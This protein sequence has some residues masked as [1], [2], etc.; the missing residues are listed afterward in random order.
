MSEPPGAS[1]EAPATVPAS[2]GDSAA[3][4]LVTF[5]VDSGNG[6]R[7]APPI[8]FRQP[9][10]AGDGPEPDAA[11]PGSGGSSPEKVVP[12]PGAGE[13]IR[14]LDRF[15]ILEFVGQGSYGTVSRAWDP[16]LQ[17]F[18]ALKELHPDAAGASSHAER[19]RREARAAV[20]LSHPGIV[21]L[22]EVLIFNNRPVLVYDF[23][24]GVTLEALLEARRLNFAEAARLV[25]ELADALAYAHSMK[26]VHRDVKPGNIL[27]ACP[28]T[29]GTPLPDP[30]TMPVDRPV[31]V[32]F[33]LARREEAEAPL[34]VEGQLL[35]TFAYMSPEQAAGQGHQA[36][37]RSD[38]YSLGVVLYKA[39][40]GELPFRGSKVTLLHSI[41]REE[42]RR[43]RSLNREIPRD[44]ES[45][46]LKAM[47]KEPE[48]R[49]QTARDFADDLRRFLRDE[50][51]VAR[52]IGTVERLWRWCRRN[53]GAAA[54]IVS[55]L[56]TAFLVIAAFFWREHRATLWSERQRYGI[57][58]KQAQQEWRAGQMPLVQKRLNDWQPPNEP[59]GGRGFEW[60]YLHRVCELELQVLRGHKEAVHGVAFSPDGRRLASVGADG[61]VILWDLA[62]G[63]EAF[64]L[65]GHNGS[66]FALAFSP[67]S[68]RLASVGG[69][70]HER[71]GFPPG[72]V[73][74]W[75]LDEHRELC[76]F[77]KRRFGLLRAVAFSPDGHYLA[78]GGGTHERGGR[79]LPGE[80]HVW[81]LVKSRE[82]FPLSGHA[83]AVTAIA[84]APNSG[85]LAAAG[86][87]GTVRVWD[88][89]RPKAVPLK[90]TT[91]SGAPLQCLAFSP[92][93]KSL[94]AA[95]WDKTVR[96]WD[97]TS[98][99]GPT[100]TR[101]PAD[102]S[103]L[104][105]A[106]KELDGPVQGLSY[107]PDGKRL[108]S[109]GRDQVVRIW[110][111][112][113]GEQLQVWRGHVGHV[114]CVAFSPDNWRL[115][116]GG[117]D[118]T[119]RIWDA[120]GSGETVTVPRD[121]RALPASGVA[122]TPDSR[123]LVIGRRDHSVATWNVSLGLARATW[124][125]HNAGVNGIALSPDGTLLASAS[126]D[127]TVQVRTFP[128]GTLLYTL[129]GHTDTVW[130]V[131]FRPEGRELA[132]ASQDGTVILW[133][134]SNGARL[135]T[136]PH[137]A[138]VR[139]VAYSPDGHA[140]TSAGAD[141]LVKVWNPSSG[142]L[143]DSLP[144]HQGAALSV[145]FSPDGRWLAS[146]GNDRQI[147]LRAFP[148]PGV[149]REFTGHMGAVNGIAFSADG[150]R[151]FSASE[152]QTLRVW[153]TA[154]R[155]LLLTLEGHD[156]P[157]RSVAVSP[158]GLQVV[159]CSSDG[160][161]KVWD[162]RPWTP[163]RGADRQAVAL[164]ASRIRPDRSVAE[165]IAE[166]R[167]D[168]T[169]SELTGEAALRL[170]DPYWQAVVH[171]AAARL[172]REL[173]S[174]NLP[175]SDL[176]GKVR[177]ATDVPESVRQ[178][179]L[180]LANQCVENPELSNHASWF[181]V[182]RPGQKPAAYELA[183]R[184]AKVAVDH[185][186]EEGSY[187]VTYGM[188]QFRLGHYQSA[189]EALTRAGELTAREGF[190]T[191]PARLAFLAMSKYHLKDK[192]GAEATLRELKALM[193]QPHW[194]RQDEAVGFLNE[195]VTLVTNH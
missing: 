50:P 17:H 46:C 72:E 96:I 29:P 143:R 129:K 166:I 162:A 173:G 117:E 57:E 191:P 34:T 123:E 134:T 73:K 182:R 126:D 124:W 156:A 103:R 61:A 45:V 131:V 130:S 70:L 167:E 89:T 33:G 141:G 174:H 9:S 85:H 67:D 152:D 8:V 87:D 95:G 47:E 181:V 161:A 51:T 159:S 186:P 23:I 74:L 132:S 177:E 56:V 25:A 99:R 36:D 39:L 98:P 185:A 175:R 81:D 52:Q 4:A 38:V 112:E 105:L 139:G 194:D 160:T 88:S 137:G 188:A 2:A 180:V 115:A 158:D 190:P 22:Y 94:A 24:R 106:F 184:Q 80:V 71:P 119:I 101:E 58:I 97:V 118:Q 107:S 113:N 178:E 64:R 55:F 147:N 195:A 44:L 5:S 135:R 151:L 63:K 187:L 31:L 142:D 149:V 60:H 32:D 179:A 93:G 150:E 157:V 108:A 165:V 116:S 153:D 109:A 146:G 176:L 66:V 30:R 83:G 27:I 168:P 138:P 54:L 49:Y 20:R 164:L 6:N 144:G 11:A 16:L 76:A 26:V 40:T 78:C 53:Q 128:A 120:A 155:Q 92:D 12:P 3:D 62:T 7:P 171:S 110:N 79:Q 13:A 140:L 43:P 114:W 136:L 37:R 10:T 121:E 154:T 14:H 125:G 145:A 82:A 77:P 59:S 84:F 41:V 48:R 15:W 102:E 19:A 90:L 75:D 86:E 69:D 18:V 183:S 148:S 91:P 21:R 104:R 192:A 163:E 133:D 193:Q 122:F 189:I 170:V 42:P 35:G 100:D 68:K 65:I 28:G 169:L 1:F 172:V 111:A 127:R